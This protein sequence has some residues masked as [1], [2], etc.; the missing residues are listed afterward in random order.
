MDI[1]DIRNLLAALET[2]GVEYVLVGSMAMAAWG[3]IRATQDVDFFV[4]P[5]PDNVRRLR[6]ALHAVFQDP[7]IE[8]ISAADLAGEYPAIQYVPPDDA[9]ITV[10]IL[11]RLGEAFR[12]EDLEWAEVLVDGVRV[13]AATPRTLVRMKRD[14]VR[15]QDRLDAAEL[16]RRF[17]LGEPDGEEP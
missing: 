5:D 1:R 4:R 2:E 16:S 12:Y 13:R 17:G 8:E 3:V 15:P 7:A 10:D 14:T 9:S 6:A 11:A